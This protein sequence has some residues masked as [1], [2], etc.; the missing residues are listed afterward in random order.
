MASKIIR[1]LINMV[2]PDSR[3]APTFRANNVIFFVIKAADSTIFFNVLG[4]NM[5]SIDKRGD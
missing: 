2:W 3:G 4:G 5:S 1:L